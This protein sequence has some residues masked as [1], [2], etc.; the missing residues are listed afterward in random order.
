M[1]EAM[2]PDLKMC[3]SLTSSPPLAR[4][5]ASEMYP[6]SDVRTDL[7]ILD[8]E[9]RQGLSGYHISGTCRMGPRGDEGAVVDP[10]L[11]VRGIESLRVADTSIMPA[12]TS[13]NTNAPVMMIVEKAADLILGKRPPPA[14]S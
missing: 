7:D 6:G 14:F 9:R 8:Y 11:R 2:A 1:R 13:G 4:F 12:N 10:E 5:C 3:R